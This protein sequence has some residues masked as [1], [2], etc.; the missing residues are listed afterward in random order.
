MRYEVC[1]YIDDGY[2]EKG[3]VKE[4]EN[5]HGDF[6]FEYRP[7]YVSDRQAI[8]TAAKSIT[9][10]EY[11]RFIAQKTID[12]LGSWSLKQRGTG[13]PL[14]VSLEW[15]LK[16]K[17]Q[18]FWRVVD[19]VTGF[20]ASDTDPTWTKAE[21]DENIRAKVKAS[22]DRAPVSDVKAAEREGN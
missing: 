9:D 4:L 10:D 21:T 7:V 18:L 17:P 15:L 11:I 20:G 16:V 19:I 13:Q 12:N 6:R 8:T 22:A 5:V 3:F 1:D 2:N 14:P